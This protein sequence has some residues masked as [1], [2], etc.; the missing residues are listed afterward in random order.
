MQ[1]ELTSISLILL[2]LCKTK[3]DFVTRNPKCWKGSQTFSL[4]MGEKV[5]T[6]YLLID[7]IKIA[8]KALAIP[9][10]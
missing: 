5:L 10:K 3:E 1:K 8:N 4:S 6:I 2:L 9:Y 7:T